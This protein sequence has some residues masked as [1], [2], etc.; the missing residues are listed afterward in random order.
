VDERLERSD[1]VTWIHIPVWRFPTELLRNQVFAWRSARWLRRNRETLDLVLANGAITWPAADV[2]VAHFVH[3]AWLQ[4]P[5]HTMRARSG[6]YAWY[7]GVY[8]A[9]NALWE[10]RAFRQARTVVAVSGRV[11]EELEGIGISPHKT[12]VIP[13]GVDLDEFTPGPPERSRFGLPEDAPL[14]ALVGDLKTPRKNVD[15]VL[16]SMTRVPDFHLAL[17]G[18]LEGSPYPAMAQKLGVHDRVHFLG[19]CA[20]VPALFRSVDVCLCPSRYEPFSL[21]LLEA[22]AA[23]CPVITSRNVGAA[24]LLPAEAGWVINDAT[25][26]RAL[27]ESIHEVMRAKPLRQMER[28]AR[29]AAEQHSFARMATA[30]V[31]LLEETGCPAT[32]RR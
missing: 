7:Q 13:N 27:T 30:Y 28:A 21:V 15:S 16:R 10:R 31:D 14:G 18:R 2:N 32:A 24:A 19:F 6:P 17:A 3:G 11:Q 20:D 8:T 12:R 9:A 29:E 25:D 4:S 5:V 22:L 23:G 1:A 26:I